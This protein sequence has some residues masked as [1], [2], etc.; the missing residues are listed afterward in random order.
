MALSNVPEPSIFNFASGHFC[1]F[2]GDFFCTNK[3]KIY[4]V[5][6]ILLGQ[7]Q[8]CGSNY[9]EIPIQD[10]GPIWIRIIF[11]RKN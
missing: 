11:E 6:K 3:I 10:F 9:I 8:C 2:V 5:R 4:F 7:Q 1:S